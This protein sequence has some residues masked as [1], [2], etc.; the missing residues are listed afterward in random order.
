MSTVPVGSILRLSS[1]LADHAKLSSAVDMIDRK[2]G[3]Q[4]DLDRL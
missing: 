4:R 2:D 3:I 1:K